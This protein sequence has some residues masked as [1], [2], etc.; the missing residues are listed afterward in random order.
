MI[1]LLVSSKIPK[2]L[3]R[4]VNSDLGFR[5]RLVLDISGP[6]GGRAHFLPLCRQFGDVLVFC[7]NRCDFALHY[8]L[9]LLLLLEAFK[10]FLGLS[11]YLH[12]KSKAIL[13]LGSS[14]SVLLP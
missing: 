3:N 11:R 5:F 9:H 8:R 14:E 1:C 4:S 12:E 6:P 7:K 10:L 2:Q 13:L